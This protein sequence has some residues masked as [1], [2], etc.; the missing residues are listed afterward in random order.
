[1]IL[2]LAHSGSVQAYVNVLD[3]G[4]SDVAISNPYEPT[5]D[6]IIPVV[7][8]LMGQGDTS[9]LSDLFLANPDASNSASVTIS[10]VPLG[11][12]SPAQTST[13]TLAPLASQVYSDVLSSLFSVD[14]GQGTLLVSSNVPLGVSARIAAR[15]DA[16]DYAGFA[17][18][19]NGGEN[20][21]GGGTAIAIGVPQ[22]DTRRTHLF[23]YNRGS[24]GTVTITGYDGDGNQIGTLSVDMASGQAARV[25][26]VMQAL[27][28]GN[29]AV[30]RI[31]VQPSDGMALFA[32][33]AEADALSGDVEV[34]KLIRM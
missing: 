24:A 1:V 30:G 19:L 23:L 29:I 25:N 18:A 3:L 14:A 13:L 16:G 2:L 21:G 7:G 15:K 6:A 33:T 4:T 32:Q 10:Y 9:F 31:T 8:T 28:A 34:A 22:T 20:I 26:S 11:G 27:G 5:V 12:T 17:P